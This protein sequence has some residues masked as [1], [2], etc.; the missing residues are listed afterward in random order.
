MGQLADIVINYLKNTPSEQ[1]KKDWDELKK[2]NISG[3]YITDILPPQQPIK[4]H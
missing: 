3:P 1:L 2:Y 4:K